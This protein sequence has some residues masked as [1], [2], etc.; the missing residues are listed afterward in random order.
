[1]EA[2]VI[3]VEHRY[4]GSSLPF[5]NASFSN[6]NLRYLTIQQALED[7][8]VII[9]ALQNEYGLVFSAAVPWITVG[10]SY[11]GVLSAWMRA[12]Y[13]NLIAGAIAASAPIRYISAEQDYT[14]FEAATADYAAQ[15]AECVQT[16]RDGYAALQQLIVAGD[17][18]QIQS[19]WRLCDLP[20]AETINHVVLWSVNSL[21]SLAQY[22]YPYPTN[23][24]A[25]LMAF[26]VTGACELLANAESPLEALGQA[27]GLFYNGTGGALECYDT[28][29]EFI[30]CA[31]QTGC[32]LGPDGT[33]WDYQVCSQ[34]VY[35]PNTNGQVSPRTSCR[36]IDRSICRL[37][38][39]SLSLSSVSSVLL[40]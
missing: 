23:F 39:L 9:T 3:F 34:F 4:Y 11:G 33:S 16:V 25:P 27:V 30:E 2:L 31:D 12:R 7:Y 15:S 29:N 22:D 1:L 37:L 18:D 20:T 38:S 36:W 13:P 14:F 24:E 5:G 19:S 40:V 32:G 8:A 17:F 21:L 10:G 6:E 28:K 26:P 35:L